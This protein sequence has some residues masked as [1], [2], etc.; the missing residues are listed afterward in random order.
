MN[1]RHLTSLLLTSHCRA[2]FHDAVQADPEPSPHRATALFTE[3]QALQQG[4]SDTVQEPSEC[5]HRLAVTEVS[6]H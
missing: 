3:T 2:D 4:A 5:I 6:W 1:E